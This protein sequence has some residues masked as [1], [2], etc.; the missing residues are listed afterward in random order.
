MSEENNYQLLLVP[1]G[2]SIEWNKKYKMY[3]CP[4]DR[5]YNQ[6][7]RYLGFCNN[8]LIQAMGRVENCI[9]ADYDYDYDY[10]TGKL[11]VIRGENP[12]TKKET[13]VTESQKE[14]LEKAFIDKGIL[15]NWKIYS[16]HKFYLLDENNFTDEI[17][18]KTL[19]YGFQGIK[20]FNLANYFGNEK[21]RDDSSQAIAELLEGKTWS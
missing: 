7:F 4:E 3:F 12:V 21:P 17:N 13:R 15:L 9:W 2:D 11:N 19:K 16:G 5:N 8:K 20:Y 1:T 6:P 18:F 10:A 14:R